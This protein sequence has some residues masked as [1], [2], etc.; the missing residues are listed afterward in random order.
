[1]EELIKLNKEWLESIFQNIDPWSAEHVAGNKLAWVR[2]YRIP[3][4]MWN[5]DCFSKVVSETTT[6]VSV[7]ESTVQ[8]EN[9]EYARLQV[10]LLKN[11]SARVSKKMRINGQTLS[12]FI[13]EEQPAKPGGQCTCHRNL[14]ESSD[15]VTSSETYVEET[16]QMGWSGED[17]IMD[18]KADRRSE[19]ETEGEEIRSG[20][21]TK[22]AHSEVSATSNPS[23][24]R[25][26][27]WLFTKEGTVGQ[28]ESAE[29]AGVYQGKPT[30]QSYPLAHDDLAKLVVEIECRGAQSEPKAPLGLD[31][32]EAHSWR[33][34]GFG[35]RRMLSDGTLLSIRKGETEADV[36][37][38]QERSTVGYNCAQ[39]GNGE[40]KRIGTLNPDAAS[41]TRENGELD[42]NGM[43]ETEEEGRKL[44]N[45]CASSSRQRKTNGLRE[46]V[47][48]NSHPRR[49]VRLSER[50]SQARKNL[51]SSEGLPI[52]S[53]SDGD[54]VNCNT[55][56]RILGN[57]E[58]PADIWG[59]GKQ[60]GLVCRKEEEEVVH[61]LQCMEDGDVEFMKKL[62]VGD[63]NVSHADL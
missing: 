45:V 16:A 2:C 28:K 43:I 33:D 21:R 20:N 18:G 15:N 47:E 10:R 44:G 38:N 46:L 56:V 11:C 57:R 39:G 8:W 53:I 3:L 1:M 42:M 24:Q 17:K 36:G 23:A 25:K 34:G 13:E 52:I 31:N 6:L 54:I 9:L 58:E 32:S 7:D 26:E 50:M 35:L 37:T 61:E 29:T 63:H 51:L 5:T 55:R 40:N 41:T 19:V 12:I 48:P 59:R 14:F 60:V 27:P 30:P 4:T 49:S 62:E 22:G